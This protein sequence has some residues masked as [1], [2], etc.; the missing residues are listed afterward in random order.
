MIRR[1]ILAL[2]CPLVLA[3]GPAPAAQPAK[4]AEKGPLKIRELAAV[5]DEIMDMKDFQT[6]MTL[7]EA[8]GLLQDKLNAKYKEDDALP[9]LVDVEAFK[10]DDPD[11]PDVYETQVK[12]PPFPRRMSV[13]TALRLAL[14]GVPTK[15]ATYL[16]RRGVIEITTLDAAS[17]RRLLRQRVT[18]SFR[19]YPLHEVIESL[20]EMTGLNVVLDQ[21]AKDKLK[22]PV[23]ATFGNGITLEGALRL[24]TDMADL[25][26]L[27]TDEYV[28]VTTPA[29]ARILRE[30]AAEEARRERLHQ[31]APSDDK[32]P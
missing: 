27:I 13:A 9:I 11:A 4:A 2:V 5:L 8:L 31:P 15:N 28:Y 6:P 17:P 7:K 18:A 22:T 3:A 23:S 21:R 14:S 30:E 24:L 1:L 25:K 20:S 26:L 19:Q 29:N 16:L 12:F 10:K 32:Q